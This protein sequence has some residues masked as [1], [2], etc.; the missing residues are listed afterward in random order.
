MYAPAV[1]ETLAILGQVLLCT[2][3]RAICEEAATSL[4]TLYS[5]KDQEE[6][7]KGVGGYDMFYA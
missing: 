4:A 5:H 1:V 6:L 7:R 3:S 2:N